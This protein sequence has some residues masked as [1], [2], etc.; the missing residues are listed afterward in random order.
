M[1][2][3][4]ENPY[5]ASATQLG[6]LHGHEGQRVPSPM[7]LGGLTILFVTLRTLV[8]V[9]AYLG[10][11]DIPR[12]LPYEFTTFSA[13][14]IGT[15][16]FAMLWT[17][18]CARNA[19]QV[20]PRNLEPNPGLIAF[21]YIIPIY[22][23]FG[24]YVGMKRIAEITFRNSPSRRP[25]RGLFLPWWIAWIGTNILNRISQRSESSELADVAFISYLVATALFITVVV[26]L[27]LAQQNL[28][29]PRPALPIASD[30]P[31][32]QVMQPRSLPGVP[33]ARGASAREVRVI[34]DKK[35]P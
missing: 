7:I 26:R 10:V 20:E 34:D 23:L 19:Q 21:S 16:I 5:T 9:L 15:G 14:A 3:N 31:L 17:Y 30:S 2:E 33:P 12:L 25:P 27:T 11:E 28:R 35:R 32:R 6:G 18:Q 8:L 22:N 4:L 13:L 1:P 29:I 24:P